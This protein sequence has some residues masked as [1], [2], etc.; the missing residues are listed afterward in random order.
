AGDAAAPVE[1]WHGPLALAG[2]DVTAIG[3]P[4]TRGAHVRRVYRGAVPPPAGA[5]PHEQGWGQAST[6]DVVRELVFERAPTDVPGALRVAIADPDGGV[7]WQAGELPAV[8]AAGGKLVRV[9]LDVDRSLVGFRQRLVHDE[10]S[11]A[12]EVRLSVANRGDAPVEVV[13]EEPLRPIGRA[14]VRFAAPS[15]GTLSA[16]YWQ[17]AVQVA[18]GKLERAAVLLAYPGTP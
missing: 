12:D 7:R 5:D 4:S 6:A 18:P 13:L 15:P 17:L 10:D 3:A 8:S 14:A 16:S 1:V 9:P 2:G 11:L